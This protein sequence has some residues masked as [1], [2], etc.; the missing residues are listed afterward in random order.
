MFTRDSVMQS[1]S[2]IH[3]Y[4]IEDVIKYTFCNFSA[5]IKCY[6]RQAILVTIYSCYAIVHPVGIF[7]EKI[8]KVE[9]KRKVLYCYYVTNCFCKYI[10]R[11][12]EK[13]KI[14]SYFWIFIVDDMTFHIQKSK[15]YSIDADNNKPWYLENSDWFL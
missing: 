2:K 9:W 13:C 14:S 4:A 1:K 11:W 8:S 10:C 12:N 15:K 3:T 7:V 6:L 5:L